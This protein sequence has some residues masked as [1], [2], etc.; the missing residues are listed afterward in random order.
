MLHNSEKKTIDH[1][2]YNSKALV[3]CKSIVSCKYGNNSGKKH[4]NC[5]G[6]V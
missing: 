3:N 5:N 1:H 4:I 2:V 6:I